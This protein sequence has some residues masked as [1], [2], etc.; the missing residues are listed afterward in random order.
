MDL[1]KA[2][3]ASADAA[4]HWGEPLHRANELALHRGSNAM[5]E[6][7]STR[8]AGRSPSIRPRREF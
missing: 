3:V 4:R 8:T 7:Q 1:A 2:S 5:V 6:G